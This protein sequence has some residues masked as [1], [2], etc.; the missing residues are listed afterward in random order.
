MNRIIYIVILITILLRITNNIYSQTWLDSA[1]VRIEALRK[2]DFSLE[3]KDE[4]GNPY[5]DSILIELIH[6]EFA[7]GGVIPVQGEDQYEWQRSVLTRYFNYGVTGNHFK[8]PWIEPVQNSL[9]YTLQDEVLDW[10]EEVGFGFRGHVLLWGG[11]GSWQMPSWTLG[12]SLTPEELY[13]A[14]ETHITRDVSYWK[15][16]IDEWDVVNEMSDGH[17]TWLA[18]TVGDSINW[19]SFKWAHKADSEAALYP[20]DYNVIVWGSTE[21]YRSKVEEMLNNGAPIGGLG[22]QGHMEGTLNWNVIKNK[23][24]YI[25]ELDI[26]I[27][28]T[29]FDMKIDE[30]NISEE[31][32][33]IS[34]ATMARLAFSH[35]AVN[36]LIF[37]SIWD[38]SAYRAGSGL[39]NEDRIPKPA[40]D[41]VYHL[42]REK[43]VTKL[44]DN[45]DEVTETYDFRG[46][47]GN[48]CI[49]VDFDGELREFIIPATWE[50]VDS[51]F[52]LEYANGLPATTNFVKGYITKDADAIELV[53]DK[54]M[55]FTSF[56]ID[57][58]KVYSADNYTI[59]NFEKIDSVTV[60]LNMENIIYH[61]KQYYAVYYNGDSAIAL[62]KGRLNWFGPVKIENKLPAF[63]GAH[64]DTAGQIVTLGFSELMNAG[65]ELSSFS[66]TVNGSEVT[67]SDATLDESDASVII[68]TLA[69]AIEYSDDIRVSYTE[70]DYCSAE[71]YKLLSFTKYV[72]NIVP[73]PNPDVISEK[74]SVQEV[75]AY[76]N[77]FDQQLI[78]ENTEEIQTILLYNSEGKLIGSYPINARDKV[79][80]DT[81]AIPYGIFVVR[82]LDRNHDTIGTIRLLK[83]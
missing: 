80:I 34:Y 38:K 61:P 19:N 82:L 51:V 12:G 67:I 55:D 50:N 31:S 13:D 11:E 43:W 45:A 58:F 46:F 4:M 77:P 5:T 47:Y 72:T 57:E 68:F 64:T 29:E 62:N 17:E 83:E 73:N 63:I 56:E 71:G 6:H 27:K 65:I 79:V 14:C 10:V 41:S 53:F 24:D 70:G 25:A 9:T 21:N 32:M 49:T 7:W 2:G 42:I 60:K 74:N 81:S 75:K 37:W 26:P 30:Q 20:N 48:Y 52:L 22:V 33:A 78:F 3:I 18:E 66:I 76:P 69:E 8:W 16:R 54:P 1:D 40:A 44:S 35:P 59:I 36:G 15:G 28:I 23:L 39:F